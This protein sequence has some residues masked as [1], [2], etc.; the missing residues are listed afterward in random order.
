MGVKN[1]MLKVSWKERVVRSCEE[2]DENIEDARCDE[3]GEELLSAGI[4]DFFCGDGFHMCLD[5]GDKR[6]GAKILNE[7]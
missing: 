1:K 5:C 3:C 6:R 4:E 2:C 7:E